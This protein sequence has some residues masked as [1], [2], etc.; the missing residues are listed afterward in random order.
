MRSKYMSYNNLRRAG[1]EENL[2]LKISTFGLRIQ[3]RKAWGFNSP[4]RIAVFFE[5][6]LKRAKKFHLVCLPI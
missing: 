6:E 5:G 4:P 3:C 1:T 2:R